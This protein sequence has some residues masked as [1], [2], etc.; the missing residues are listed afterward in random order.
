M[1]PNFSLFFRIVESEIIHLDE[2]AECDVVRCQCHL[3]QGPDD[4]S[5][6][7]ILYKVAQSLDVLCDAQRYTVQ[8]H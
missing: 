3:Q 1:L 7:V 6:I 2:M 4:S 8:K 5:S